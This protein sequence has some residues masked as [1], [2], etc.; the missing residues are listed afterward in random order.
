MESFQS[1]QRILTEVERFNGITSKERVITGD[2]K[3]Y[4][5]PHILRV[6]VMVCKI[7]I[8]SLSQCVEASLGGQPQFI[9]LVAISRDLGNV[10]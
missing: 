9:R 6:L 1:Q 3:C 8:F 7:G 2:L 5:G 4:F 10:D